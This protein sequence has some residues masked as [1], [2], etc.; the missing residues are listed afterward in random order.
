MRRA[1]TAA[2]ESS[3]LRRLAQGGV[4]A[5]ADSHAELAK[6]EAAREKLRVLTL[7]MRTTLDALEVAAQEAQGVLD[8][9]E[10]AAGLVD[11]C[12]RRFDE[13]PIGRP[14]GGRRKA[15]PVIDVQAKAASAW[16]RATHG[17]NGRPELPTVQ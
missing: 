5:L 15:L 10:T 9:V 8:E 14:M 2:R 17:K 6:A 7:Q 16:K 3:Q 12:G 11:D 4:D 1:S 13:P